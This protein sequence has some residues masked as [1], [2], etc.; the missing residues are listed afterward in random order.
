MD[1]L[2]KELNNLPFRLR[3]HKEL[4]IIREEHGWW[5][6]Y[7][8]KTLADEIAASDKSLLKAVHKLVKWY[9][10]YFNKETNNGLES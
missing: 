8:G 10:N 2:T 6:G 7:E 4:C 3:N 5:I 9:P 1:K